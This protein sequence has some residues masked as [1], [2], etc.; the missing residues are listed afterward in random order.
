[1]ENTV[2]TLSDGTKVLQ[3][4]QSPITLTIEQLQNQLSMDTQMLAQAQSQVTQAQ[5]QVDADNA[6]IEMLTK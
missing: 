1:M 4:P 5:A 6:N 2:T 3:I